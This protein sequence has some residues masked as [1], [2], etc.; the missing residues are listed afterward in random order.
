M[1]NF[2]IKNIFTIFVPTQF[3]KKIRI[4]TVVSVLGNVLMA[5]AFFFVGPVPFVKALPTSVGLIQ[6]ST[7]MMGAGYAL[8]MVSTFGRAQAAAIRNGFNDDLG[9]YVFISSTC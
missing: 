8:I 2:F 1:T 7:A 5:L 9:T 3:C 4:L 6:A